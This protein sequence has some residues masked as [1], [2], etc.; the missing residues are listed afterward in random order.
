MHF[1]GI[2]LKYLFH[3]LGNFESKN[4]I[5]EQRPLLFRFKFFFLDASFHQAAQSVGGIR[6]RQNRFL[7]PKQARLAFAV[8][9]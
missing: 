3:L 4:N 7:P 1:N 5:V 2:T 6:G 9:T 8:E